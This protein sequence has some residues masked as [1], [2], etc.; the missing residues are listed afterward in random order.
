MIEVKVLSVHTSLFETVLPGWL[1]K[2]WTVAGFS[3]DVQQDTLTAL[4]VR[5]VPAEIAPKAETVTEVKKLPTPLTEFV[6]VMRRGNYVVLDTE[7]TGLNDA[8]IC[9]IA[10]VDPSGAVLLDTLVEPVRGIP[11]E[12]ARIHG[13]TNER[14]QN[15]PGWAEI[16]PRVREILKG[17]DVVV[18]N[19]VYDRKMMH[20][21]GEKAGIEKIDWKAESRWFCAMEAYAEF[22]GDW[23]EYRR[24]FRW[25]KL[26]DAAA[27]CGV[28]FQGQA[29]TAL[30][31]TLAALGVSKW[32][33]ENV[34]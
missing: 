6:G 17:K 21:S 16:A 32:L 14:V 11:A 3:A 20:Q 24:S 25:H 9:Q 30:A 15:A 27:R 33:M 34:K 5:T 2:G 10:I 7:T 8:E 26:T 12:A 13:I 18:Y 19:A 28:R 22:V 31:D 1:E 23:N 29:H 4:L